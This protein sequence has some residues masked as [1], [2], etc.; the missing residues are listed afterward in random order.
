MERQRVTNTFIF[1]T[2]LKMMMKAVPDPRARYDLC[3]R[4]IMSAGKWTCR[5]S[6]GFHVCPGVCLMPFSL[7]AVGPA[8]LLTQ[9]EP[10][11]AFPEAFE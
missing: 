7:E 2:A 11:R 4:G 6:A 9:N 1:P 10:G 5:S 3:L 8:T